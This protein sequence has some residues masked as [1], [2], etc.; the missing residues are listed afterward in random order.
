MRTMLAAAILLVAGAAHAETLDLIC[1]GSAVHAEP[2][3]GAGALAP[4]GAGRD[5]S[6]D[7]AGLHRVRSQ[8]T[9]QVQI[10]AKG[11]G[12]IKP[13][14]AILPPIRLGRDG[15]WR[16][17]HLRV[18]ESEIRG[19]FSLNFI[20]HPTVLLDRRTGDIDVQGMGLR[21]DGACE[22]AP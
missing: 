3:Q 14:P 4:N 2:T 7:E 13:P 18:S 22:K 11:A 19:T 21:F 12:R 8:E 9:L 1:R 5:F 10:D 15:W 20:N 16:L 6:D 17:D